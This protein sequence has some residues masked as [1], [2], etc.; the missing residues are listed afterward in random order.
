ML[1]SLALTCA[2]GTLFAW[3]PAAIAQTPPKASLVDLAWLAGCWASDS[4]DAGSSEQWMPLAGGLLLGTSRT[5][6]GGRTVSFEFMRILDGKDGV[7]VFIALP[8]GQ[9]ETHFPLASLI[10]GAAVFENPAHDFPQRVIYKRVGATQLHARIEGTRNG[11]V[12]GIDYP[13]K[14]VSCDA[15]L[16]SK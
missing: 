9:R 14:R 1:R 3:V 7:P 11:A 5:V 8:S 10:D 4:A 16:T 2:A 12:R 13:M 6:K 15:Q